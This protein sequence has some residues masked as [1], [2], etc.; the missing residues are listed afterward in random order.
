MSFR[1]LPLAAI[2]GLTA[3]ND[4]PGR[5]GP[6]PEV[7]R[8]DQVLNFGVLYKENCSGCHGVDGKGGASIALSNPV[9]LAIADDSV[10]RSVMS[11]GVHA[12]EMPPFAQ[13]KGGALTDKQIGVLVAGI[14]GW[15]RPQAVDANLPPYAATAPGDAV[16]GADA[17]KRFC[18]VC[19]GADG[20]GGKR[21]SSIVNGSYLALVSDQYLRTVV[22]AGHGQEAGAPNWRSAPAG[23][24]MTAQEVTDVVAWL[25]AQR[26]AYPGQ[27]YAPQK[28]EEP[29][30]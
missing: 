14:R 7:I 17:Y 15:A 27:P 5:P 19:H 13:S 30:K 21:G 22:I 10:L 6:R 2:L 25:A 4:L 12:T 16:R 23:P 11:S 9:Y 28:Q 24:P 1:L 18:S 8:P 20:R 3:C 29:S 26:P